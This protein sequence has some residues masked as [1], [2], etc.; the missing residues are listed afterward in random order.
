MKKWT[1]SILI[2][3]SILFVGC[4]STPTYKNGKKFTFEE[5]ELDTTLVYFCQDKPNLAPMALRAEKAHEYFREKNNA[6][7]QM[8]IDSIGKEKTKGSAM[9]TFQKRAKVLALALHKKFSCT[10]IDAI[11]H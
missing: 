10:L 6:N 1:I 4:S 8:L 7:T 5:K 11:V 9:Q 2:S 3:S